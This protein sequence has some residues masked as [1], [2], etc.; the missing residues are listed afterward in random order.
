M[1]PYLSSYYETTKLIFDKNKN[2]GYVNTVMINNNN[3]DKGEDYNEHRK[4]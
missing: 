1:Q 4:F 3:E 2:Q